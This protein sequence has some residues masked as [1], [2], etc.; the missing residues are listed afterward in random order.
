[1]LGIV[2]D[3]YQVLGVVVDHYQVFGVVVAH[4]KPQKQVVYRGLHEF[5]NIGL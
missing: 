2:V 4:T 3:H 1:M 5:L